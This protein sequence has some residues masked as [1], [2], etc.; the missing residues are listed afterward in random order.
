M[1]KTKRAIKRRQ[2]KKSPNCL[3]ASKQTFAQIE[4]WWGDVTMRISRARLHFGS[5]CAVSFCARKKNELF[6]TTFCLGKEKNLKQ[7]HN[8]L[9]CCGFVLHK[10][11]EVHKCLLSTFYVNDKFKAN[12]M[13][14]KALLE[15]GI[16][17]RNEFLPIASQQRRL[18][19]ASTAK[20][21]RKKRREGEKAAKERFP[22]PETETTIRC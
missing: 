14:H 2:E 6:L 21:G 12:F 1:N 4:V 16:F 13:F 7:Q 15:N 8:G 19:Q 3:H 5:H 22:L 9:M 18:R 20:K 11:I 17:V 10:S